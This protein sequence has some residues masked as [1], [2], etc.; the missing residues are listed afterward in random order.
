MHR[1][2]GVSRLQE[3]CLG[4]WD[5]LSGRAALEPVLCGPVGGST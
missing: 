2:N 5:Q 1:M 3:G 4:A